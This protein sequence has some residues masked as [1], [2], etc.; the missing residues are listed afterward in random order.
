MLCG[1]LL[2][3]ESE[4]LDA[5]DAAG[6]PYVFAGRLFGSNTQG[7][8]SVSGSGVAV[9]PGVVLTAAH[10]YWTEAWEDGSLPEGASPWRSYRN[11]YPAASSPVSESFDTVV[12]V[13]SLAGYDDALHD[14]DSNRQDGTSPFEAFNRDS[15]L[16]IFSD[17]TATPHGMARVHPRAAESGF[18]SQKNYYEVVGYPSAK[19][20]GSDSRRWNLHKTTEEDPV[21]ASRVPSVVYD[22]GYTFENRLYTGGDPLNSYSGN[23]G[24]PVF[25]RARASESWL[26]VGVYVGSGA[27]FRAMDGELAD[28]IDVANAGQINEQT[29]RFRFTGTDFSLTEGDPPIQ[30]GVERLGDATEAVEVELEVV[31]LSVEGEPDYNHSYELSWQGGETGIKQVTVEAI[32]DALREGRETHILQLNGEP[33]SLAGPSTVVVTIEDNDLNGPL[34]QWTT[35]DEVGAVDYSEVVFAEGKFVSVGGTNAIRWSPDYQDI[36]VTDFP[37]LNRLFQITHARGLFIGSGDGPQIILSEDAETWEVIEL[38]TS[39][40]LFSI[41]YG[42]GWFVAV[43]GI[44]ALGASQGEIWISQDARTWINA[45][46]ERHDR[47]DDVEFGNGLFLAR[48]GSDF[49]RSFD[50]LNWEQV[51][52]SGLG[53]VP[54]DLEYGDG[55]FVNAGRLGGIY[56]TEDGADWTLVRQEDEEPFYGVG[57]RNGYFVAT[58]ISGKLATSSD[59]GLTWVDRIPDTQENLWHGVTAVG[60]MVVIGDNGHLMTSDLPEFFDFLYEPESQSADVGESVRFFTEFI[61]SKTGPY[62]LQWRKDGQ[63]IVGQVAA[64]LTIVDA[65]VSDEGDYQLIVSGDGTE[66]ASAIATLDVI[67]RINPPENAVASTATSR[68]VRLSWEDHSAGEDGYQVERRMAGS[69]FWEWVIT[70]GENATSHIDRR[71]QPDTVYE[72]R[73]S[74]LFE[75]GAFPQ[76]PASIKTL[77]ATNV[78][79]LSTRGLVG[80]NDEVMIGGFTIPQGPPMTL[81]IRGLGP[82][83]GSSGI[84]DAIDNPQLRLIQ[85]GAE[86]PI[87]I[88][89]SDWMDSENVEEILATGLTPADDRESAILTTLP[90]GGYTIILS[91]EID[92]PMAVGM[93][94][95]YDITE[96]CEDCRLVNLSTRGPVSV[97]SDLMI[98]GLVISGVAEKQILVRAL[99][100]SLSTVATALQDPFLRMVSGEGGEAS[101]DNWSDSA[102]A[103]EIARLGLPFG[104][105]RESGEL[106]QFGAGTYTFLISGVEETT[107]IALLEIFEVE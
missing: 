77:P 29:P 21:V 13:V 84:A 38:P 56:I 51:E 20:S 44:D 92:E 15:L 70:L 7:G 86:S 11:W 107:G 41:Q 35:V 80:K 33:E 93:I 71:L 48:A 23:S 97:G 57:Y 85:T 1:S 96:G 24:G 19:Y 36:A 10:V 105:D 94:E 32:D 58:G 68:G 8:S 52:L 31:N 45:Y 47:F 53:G 81:Y 73:I 98:G 12:S 101:I 66:Y 78:I 62:T 64:T 14:Y 40:S 2:W 91:S 83:L 43:G 89:N 95:I 49:Y 65:D 17:G 42:H 6:A 30:V 106:Y 4:P 55:V 103:E 46:D 60:K 25:G 79:N 69:D 87:E 74:T 75:G 50:A 63:D 39:V 88:I 27:L 26:L 5:V 37:E 3:G 102:N 76:E 22:G 104:D 99:G 67:T 82:S 18:M 100:P 16:L 9:G 59:G 61:S 54:S 72:Y 34:D 90:S 28:M